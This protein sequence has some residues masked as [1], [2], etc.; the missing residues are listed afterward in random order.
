MITKSP[1][2]RETT[3]SQGALI[4]GA[5]AK[6]TPVDADKFSIRDSVTELLQSVSWA[7]LKAAIRAYTDTLYF[8]LAGKSGGQTAIGGIGVT[9]ILKLQGTSGNGTL[10]SPAIQFL[11]GNNGA[12]ISG[13]ILN[14]GNV[15]IGTTSPASTLSVVST[16]PSGAGNGAVV[17]TTGAGT[18]VAIQIGLKVS[19]LA[20]YT[21]SASNFGLYAQNQTAGT[22]TDEFNNSQSANYGEYIATTTGYIVGQAGYASGGNRSYG[23][24]FRAIVSKN[25][26][27]NIGVAGY[28]LNSGT[29]PIVV[30]GYF[31][32][33][34]TSPTFVSSALIADNGAIAVPIFIG[35]DNGTEVFRLD[36]GGNVGVNTTSPSGKLD[37]HGAGTTTGKN[38]EL[39]D[40]GGNAKVTVLDNGA[41]TFVNQITSSLATGTSPFAVTSTTV[42][43]NLNADTV[44]GKHSFDLLLTA[45]GP[46]TGGTFITVDGKTVTYSAA[47]QITGVV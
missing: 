4:N 29:S 5:T 21:G 43:T 12:T 33:Q 28:A 45:S 1:G 39:A 26:A 10:T 24:M 2:N 18:V 34:N 37:V 9:D 13:T 42:N 15:G 16:L 22:S 47:G 46:G 8:I 32:L 38:F 11:V 17:S 19:L 6:T 30:G 14:N 3:V 35:R 25:S 41:T 27:T 44:D 40:S 20:G 31:G 36:D 7:A 23:G